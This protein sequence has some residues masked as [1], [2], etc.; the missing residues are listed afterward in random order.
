MEFNNKILSIDQVSE[1]LLK[2]KDKYNEIKK[3]LKCLSRTFPCLCFVR[4]K[5]CLF[6][7]IFE[8]LN[9]KYNLFLDEKYL[10]NE[11]L[12]FEKV[13][14]ETEEVKIWLT[15]N[16]QIGLSKLNW[17]STA[18]KYSNLRLSFINGKNEIEFEYIKF[19]IVGDDFKNNYDFEH[20]F[21]DLFFNKEILP[22]ELA[23]WK[24]E[25]EL[26]D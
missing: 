2:N 10:E 23:K 20:L 16:L 13:K 19:Q 24:Y 6:I 7:D 3:P 17:F 22:N 14:N 1:Y 25:N 18:S 15:K 12:K 21:C 11:L 4:D 5:V 9:E 26:T 8:N